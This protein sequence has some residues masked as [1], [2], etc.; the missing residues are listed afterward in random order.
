[1]IKRRR[2]FPGSPCQGLPGASGS[3]D[4]HR[5]WPQAAGLIEAKTYL[6]PEKNYSNDV[7]AAFSRDDLS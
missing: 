7:G 4:R 3:R 6:G 2:Q 5:R 1:M